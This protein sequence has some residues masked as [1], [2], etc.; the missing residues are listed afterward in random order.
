MKKLFC[1][2]VISLTLVGCGSPS[3]QSLARMS[4]FEL[5][6]YVY[7]R[8][9]SPFYDYARAYIEEL[10]SRNVNDCNQYDNQIREANVVRQQNMNNVF[11]ALAVG[12]IATGIAN[13]GQSTT[14]NTTNNVIVQ[15]KPLPPVN[16]TPPQ[17]IPR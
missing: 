13:S 1:L 6:D 8:Q 12:T 4:N 17:T 14:N 7:Q 2:S 10:R 15:P 5:C 9:K 3:K 16:I 11:N